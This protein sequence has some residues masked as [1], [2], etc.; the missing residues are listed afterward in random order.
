[1]E[2]RMDKL[3]CGLRIHSLCAGSRKSPPLILLHGYPTNALLWRNCIPKLAEHFHV[4]APDLPGHGESD[5][6]LGVDYDLDFFVGFL[7]EYVQMM[8]LPPVHLAVHDLGGVPGLGFVTRNPSMVTKFIV[9]DTIPYTEWS[10]LLHLIVNRAKSPFWSRWMLLRPI[11]RVVL[12]QVTVFSPQ[13]ITAET[14]EIYRKPWI[15]NGDTRK[16]FRKVVSMPPEKIAVP[17]KHLM[18]IPVPTLILWAKN[19]LILKPAIAKKLQSDIPNATLKIVDRCGHFLQEDRPE[20][21]TEHMLYFL[22]K[23]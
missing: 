5:K 8:R 21:V 19:D 11:F 10:K 22:L 3:A 14:S 13:S 7:E 2:H 16:A 9:M 17:R 6:P 12:K 1:M 15:K 18:D 23:N 4:C 20:K